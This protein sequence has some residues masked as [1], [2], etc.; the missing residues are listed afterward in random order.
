MT[1]LNVMITD[2]TNIVAYEIDHVGYAVVLWCRLGINVI[3]CW[4]AL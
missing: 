4:F 2:N 1:S 3:G